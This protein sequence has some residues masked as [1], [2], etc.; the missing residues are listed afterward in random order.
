MR[1]KKNTW[2][3]NQRY[4]Y[5]YSYTK[6]LEH[7]KSPDYRSKRKLQRIFDQSHCEYY[8]GV[9]IKNWIIHCCFPVA[10]LV[11]NTNKVLEKFKVTDRH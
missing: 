9:E 11:K 5:C 4:D 7:D 3:D 10:S 1:A 8:L 2:K 6:V